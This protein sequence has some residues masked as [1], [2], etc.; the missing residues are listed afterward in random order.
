MLLQI[1]IISVSLSIDA[2]GIGISYHLKGVKITKLSRAI[3]AMMSVIIMYTSLK[4]GAFLAAVFPETV[5]QIIGISIL[6][7]IGLTFIRN[8]IFGDENQIYDFDKSKTID[9]WEAFILGIALSAD[10]FS[11]G[12]AASAIGI[13]GSIMPFTVGFMQIAFLSIGGILI[14]KSQL[15]KKLN[16]KVCGVFSGF[17]LILIAILRTM[18]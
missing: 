9:F 10:A 13:G 18:A 7:L 4:I 15:M 14:D 3:I 16:R 12:I 5:I 6:V 17:L 1:L 8:S 2:L 11:A